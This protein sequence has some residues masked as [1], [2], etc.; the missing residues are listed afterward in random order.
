M[1]IKE[2]TVSKK[3]KQFCEFPGVAVCE[4][5]NPPTLCAECDP[6]FNLMS[7]KTTCA[8]A[9]CQKPEFCNIPKNGTGCEGDEGKQA[10]QC[11]ECRH[12]YSLNATT[13]ICDHQK[14]GVGFNANKTSG[15]CDVAICK[16]PA[17][18]KQQAE[19]VVECE[20]DNPPALCQTCKAGY[21]IGEGGKNCTLARCKKAKTCE[22]EK[23]G[24]GCEAPPNKT[25]PSMCEKCRGNFT[26]DSNT[27]QC[28]PQ[29]C[30]PGENP[31]K[32]RR[33]IT[34]GDHSSQAVVL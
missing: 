15:G 24:R 23:T 1:Q 14:C 28:N 18:C 6:G 9:I 5:K 34:D 26:L 8:L 27:S 10:T 11:A 4:G 21:N 31:N 20:G 17:N 16:K 25:A 12:G 33:L 22:L 2:N 7:K 32:V 29:P 13:G 30:K 3:S 19:R